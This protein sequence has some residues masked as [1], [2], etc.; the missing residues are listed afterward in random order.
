MKR[1]LIIVLA[2]CSIGISSYAQTEKQ[3]TII[4][5]SRD[6]LILE[7]ADFIAEMTAYQQPRFKLYKTENVYN[8]IKLD[9]AT[10]RV[11]QVQYSMNKNADAMTV[12]IDNTS[13]LREDETIRA[14]RFEL[15]PTNN[16]Y[17]FILLDTEKGYTYQVQWNTDPNK[18]FREWIL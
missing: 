8:L 7:Y 9:T 2:I 4:L 5:S 15:Y 3:D 16:M 11:W 1:L 10:G 18:R 6:S 12:P 17:T 13:L 14:G